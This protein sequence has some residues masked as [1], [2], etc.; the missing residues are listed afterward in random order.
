[1]PESPARRSLSTEA[2]RNLAN[3]TNTVPQVTGVTPRW[4]LSL[5]PWVKVEA[6]VYR[7]NRRRL[8]G[9]DSFRI[10]LRGLDTIDAA[11]LKAIH[12]FR[13]VDPDLLAAVARSFTTER[14][15]AGEVV[16]TEGEGPERFYIVARGKVEVTTT[17]RHGE[18]LRLRVLSEGTYFGE[19]ALLNDTTRSATVR[20]LTPVVL[21]S[22]GGA[23]FRTMLEAAPQLRPAL[24]AMNEARQAE[25]E[26]TNE[27]GEADIDV[28]SDY[29]GEA[30]VPETFVDYEVN[31][32]EY[33]LSLAQSVVNVH[34]RITDLFSQPID[35]LREQLRLTIMALRERE[36]WDLVNNRSFGLL[37]SVAPWMR[38]PTRGGP[39]TPDDMDE[40]L[41]VA[42]KEPG[43]FLAHP[44]AIAAFGREC[45]RRGVPPP[46]VQMY[47][48]P[49]LTW[50]GVPIVPCDKLLVDGR[51]RPTASTGRTT[52]L[53]MRTGESKQGVVGLCPQNLQGEQAPGLSVRA[54]GIDQ[55]SIARYLVTLYYSVAVLT[56]DAIAA[57]EDVE[58]GSYHEYA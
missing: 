37:H 53:L 2:A 19:L 58:V 35:Q 18:K 12:I 56:D 15:K 31:P 24:L 49:F 11:G 44:R 16:V 33:V 22:L 21:L 30:T 48:S 1:M 50:R 55:N 41:S 27:Y 7:V 34:T 28:V 51:S 42:W 38:M 32:R 23:Q 13:N 39:P 54:M 45:T 36:E 52:I 4:L 46:T 6:G 5:L 3:T 40:L 14:Y 57:L 29:E 25:S 26:R 20:A 10:D 17:G 47:G 9:S 43:F 8:I